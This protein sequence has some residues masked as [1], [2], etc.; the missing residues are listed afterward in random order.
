MLVVREKWQNNCYLS[1]ARQNK[2]IKGSI[3]ELKTKK[4]NSNQHALDSLTY[5][6]TDL[7]NLVLGLKPGA[8]I[9]TP[10]GTRI[11]NGIK[12]IFLMLLNW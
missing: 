5:A 9:N 11:S 1:Y 6:S 8:T 3:Y 12:V 2:F 4:L 10:K 7:K